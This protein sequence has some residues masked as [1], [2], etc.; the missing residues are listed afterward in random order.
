M[1]ERIADVEERVAKLRDARAPWAY[2]ASMDLYLSLIVGQTRVVRLL[3]PAGSR[4]QSSFRVTPQ[5]VAQYREF[6]LGPMRIW[7]ALSLAPHTYLIAIFGML[8]RLDL[9]LWGRLLLG[10]VLFVLVIFWQ[11]RASERTLA[12]LAASGSSPLPLGAVRAGRPGAL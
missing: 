8:D 12:A 7:T 5:T 6:N 9:Y 3:D 10:N 1:P 2:R 11:R 4:E